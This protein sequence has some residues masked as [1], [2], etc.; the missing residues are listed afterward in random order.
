MSDD[1]GDRMKV[2]ESAEAGRR[3]M[4]QLPICARIDGKGFS[5]FTREL[6]RPYDERLS[7]LM[8]ATTVH[9]V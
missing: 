1:L 4:D 2:Y 3:L 8:V 6:K 5:K 7:Q 9:L